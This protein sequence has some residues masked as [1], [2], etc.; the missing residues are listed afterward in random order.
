M[1][2]TRP[3][4]ST[5]GIGFPALFLLLR[6]Y[7]SDLLMTHIKACRTVPR[8]DAADAAFH[9]AHNEAAAKATGVKRVCIRNRPMQAPG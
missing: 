3:G 7:D 8:P 5:S 9:S 6:P 4:A 2:A 1:V